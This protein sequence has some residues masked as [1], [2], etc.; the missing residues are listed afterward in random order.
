[1]VGFAFAQ[2]QLKQVPYVNESFDDKGLFYEGSSGGV[3]YTYTSR[4]TYKINSMASDGVGRSIV[5]DRASDFV[6][7]VDVRILDFDEEVMSANAGVIFR[8][9]TGSEGES[10]YTFNIDNSR[11]FHAGR[12]TGDKFTRFYPGQETDA[13][14]SGWNTLKVR[15][16]E[17]KID[18]YINGKNVSSLNDSTIPSGGYGLYTTAG[19]VAEFDNFVLDLL[20]K[21]D[22]RKQAGTV[23]LPDLKFSKFVSDD[24]TGLDPLFYEGEDE[25][26]KFQYTDHESYLI[27]LTSS[28][29]PTPSTVPGEIAEGRVSVDSFFTFSEHPDVDHAGLIVRYRERDDGWGDYYLLEIY[30]SGH[31]RF[32]RVMGEE[33]AVLH[34]YTATDSIKKAGI[35]RLEIICTGTSFYI[36]INEIPLAV[37]EDG[38]I[39]KGGYGV[40]LSGGTSAEFQN[41]LVEVVRGSIDTTN[42]I[43]PRPDNYIDLTLKLNDY[44]TCDFENEEDVPFAV[45]ERAG[46]KLDLRDGS[47]VID[48]T[49]AEIDAFSF[50]LGRFS[51]YRASVELK[52]L[53]GEDKLGYG[54]VFQVSPSQTSYIAFVITND[55]YYSIQKS[56]KGTVS[57]LVDWTESNLIASHSANRIEVTRKSANFSFLINGELVEMFPIEGLG[58]GGLGFVAA[59]GMK[60][61]FDDFVINAPD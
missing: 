37:V 22:I 13:T 18:L 27:D 40:Y 61:V 7:S 41:F 19:T 42:M 15:C 17:D 59:K 33:I 45:G 53:D 39:D 10:Y 47:Y 44:F 29:W 48:A 3:R 43:E 8:V 46:F 58:T 16:V 54:L 30:S 14:K 9:I 60:V 57:M 2:I 38:E 6:L 32:V 25:Y 4:G 36:V 28:P 23:D 20:L 5:E 56:D 31:Y 51:R 24:F 35:N 50:I 21:P 52:K 34:P 26:G 55:G 11:R 12:F 1:M 49:E